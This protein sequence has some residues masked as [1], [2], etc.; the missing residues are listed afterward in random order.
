MVV[1]VAMMLLAAA[2]V[3]G[4]L[5]TPGYPWA[6]LGVGPGIGFVVGGARPVPQR[7]R[8]AAGVVV[9]LLGAWIARGL[10]GGRDAWPH[11][12]W[13]VFVGACVGGA[14]GLALLAPR[15][16]G[17][18]ALRAWLVSL[19]LP[20]ATASVALFASY[21]A[22]D[23]SA[24]QA[25]AILD[26]ELWWDIGANRVEEFGPVELVAGRWLPPSDEASA[27]WWTPARTARVESLFANEPQ[28]VK[29]L[30]DSGIY[31]ACARLARSAEQLGTTLAR[32]EL[33]RALE[34]IPPLPQ[35]PI[36]LSRRTV[37][38]IRYGACP[39][40]WY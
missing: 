17:V 28:E 11:G 13:M 10:T 2:T 37:V 15:V 27:Y 7:V 1:S 8:F 39:A 12:L 35:A 32:I 5:R 25:L 14:L 33:W 21:W 24:P 40:G 20:A 19:V 4:A 30:G 23:G 22:Y 26:G 31:P 3:L 6:G 29:L 18:S 34:R 9:F 38:E 36:D 16:G